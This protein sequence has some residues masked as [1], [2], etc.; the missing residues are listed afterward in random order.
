MAWTVRGLEVTV[1]VRDLSQARY[2]LKEFLIG[3][4]KEFGGGSVVDGRDGCED[5]GLLG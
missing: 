4:R 3:L 1:V 5:L 2:S